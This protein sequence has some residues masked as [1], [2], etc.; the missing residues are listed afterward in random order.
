MVEYHRILT[1]KIETKQYRCYKPIH[2]KLKNRLKYGVKGLDCGYLWGV[3]KINDWEGTQEE[4]FLGPGTVL[5]AELGGDY[6]NVYDD[7]LSCTL[8]SCILFHMCFILD[9]KK[10]FKWIS[11]NPAISVPKL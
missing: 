9:N 6:M 7:S 2:I 10:M 3:S 11:F 5:F 1:E 8:R 4:A